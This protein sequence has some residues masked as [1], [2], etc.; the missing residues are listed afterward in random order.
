VENFRP[1]ASIKELDGTVLREGY[2]W[3]ANEWE[4]L[5]LACA[6]CSRLHKVNK[7]P[8]CWTERNPSTKPR[9]A[10]GEGFAAASMR[11]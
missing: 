1:K 11:C 10:G 8:G 7:F 2:W 5:Y 6:D 3:L 4:N 9:V